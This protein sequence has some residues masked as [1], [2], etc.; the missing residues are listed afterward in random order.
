MKNNILYYQLLH[1]TFK[2]GKAKQVQK[3]HEAFSTKLR[4]HDSYLNITTGS[5]NK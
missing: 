1:D 2:Y 5:F 4:G 3:L